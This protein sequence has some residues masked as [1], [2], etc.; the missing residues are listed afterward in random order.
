MRF[1]S[2]WRGWFRGGF[3]RFRAVRET[4]ILAALRA[5][6]MG[7]MDARPR[8]ALADS[9]NPGLN[10][11]TPLGSSGCGASRGFM[12]LA[13]SNFRNGG[14]SQRPAEGATPRAPFSFNPHRRARSDAPYQPLLSLN[15]LVNL[16]KYFLGSVPIAAGVLRVARRW[17]RGGR[18][19]ARPCG[20]RSARMAVEFE[21]HPSFSIESSSARKNQRER[22]A[23]RL[24][25]PTT[26]LLAAHY[27]LGH[28]GRRE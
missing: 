22:W 15:A 26:L 5:K 2:F 18:G 14:D 7:R 3:I 27:I 1:T 6:W 19:R 12:L 16:A 8:V 21:R 11:A 10:A 20:K 9:G 24:I 4:E 25:A 17:L 23:G 13:K 28:A